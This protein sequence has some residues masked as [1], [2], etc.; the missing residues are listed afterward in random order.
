MPVVATPE[1]KPVATAE[2]ASAESLIE[3]VVGEA[4]VRLRGAIDREQLRTV[5]DCLVHQG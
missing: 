5:M 4:T 3:I 1:P 2:R